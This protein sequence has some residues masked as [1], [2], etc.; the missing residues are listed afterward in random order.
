MEMKKDLST[1]LD[2]WV[3]PLGVSVKEALSIFTWSVC[4]ILQSS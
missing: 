1:G 3:N 2:P 4:S